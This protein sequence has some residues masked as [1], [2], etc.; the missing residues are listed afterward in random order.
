MSFVRPF[1]VFCLSARAARTAFCSFIVYLPI[2]LRPRTC[3]SCYDLAL[4]LI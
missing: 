3:L 2:V 1:F 4:S